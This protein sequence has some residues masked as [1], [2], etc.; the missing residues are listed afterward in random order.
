M[1]RT[2][3][4]AVAALAAILAFDAD[5]PASAQVPRRPAPPQA[6]ARPKAAPK[7]SAR[8]RPKANAPVGLIV[9]WPFPPALIIRQTPEAHDEV[10]ALL[11]ML[12]Y[13]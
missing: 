9:P 6:G 10:Q 3:R 2:C 12:R 8:R 1:N 4:W 5:E 13:Y 7:R 11:N